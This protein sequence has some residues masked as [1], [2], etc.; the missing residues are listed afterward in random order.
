MDLSVIIP[1]FNQLPFTKRMWLSLVQTLPVNLSIEV[2]IID[3]ASTDGTSEWLRV[4]GDSS[5]ECVQIK[6]LCILRNQTNRGY[7]K[8]NNLAAKNAQG[9]V[10][11]LLNNDLLFEPT[12]LEPMLAMFKKNSVKPLIV[13][14]VQYQADSRV[15][16]HAGIEVRLGVESNRPVIEHRRGSIPTI[17]EKVFAVTGACCLIQRKAFE[18][19]GGF[20]EQYVNGGEDVDLCMKVIQAGGRC[21]I[22]PE[23]RVFHHVSQTRGQQFDRDERNSWRLFHNW[24][25]QIACEL[26]RSCARLI[27]N[28][29]HEDPLIKCLAEAF[30]VGSRSLAPIAV[31]K[32][33]QKLVQAE[34][35][36]LEKYFHLG[37]SG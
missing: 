31:K 19:L 17:S 4:L 15:L 33:A 16:D 28:D 2:I 26:E 37:I 23:S 25:Q 10:L 29:L 1:V 21:L 20:D 30:L 36:R 7:A 18:E 12:W 11:A 13:G 27:A 22:V 14:N 34:L 5:L 3:D 24:Q 9:K 6:S 35:S 8:S 32:M